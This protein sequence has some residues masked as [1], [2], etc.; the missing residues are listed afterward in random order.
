MARKIDAYPIPTVCPYCDSE[1]IFTSNS[2]IYGE[3]Y[4]NGKCYKCTKCDAYVGVH[5]GTKTPLGRM[6]NKELRELKKQAHALFDPIW[7]N[8]Q[9]T[10]SEAYTDLAKALSIPKKEC[11]FGWFDKPM[12]LKAIGYLTPK[13]NPKKLLIEI[14]EYL[15]KDVTLTNDWGIQFIRG[16][17]KTIK[18]RQAL[19]EKQILHIQKQYEIIRKNER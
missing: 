8:K 14:F 12:L 16:V 7:Q 19:S 15:K 13:E 1:V 17:L 3:K 11:H 18:E 4:G 10:R 9:K 2:I 6:A 5:N